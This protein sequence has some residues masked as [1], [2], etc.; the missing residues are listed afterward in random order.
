MTAWW[1]ELG[2]NARRL[3]HDQHLTPGALSPRSVWSH[4]HG[5]CNKKRRK[6]SFG[7]KHTF[8]THKKHARHS[9]EGYLYA[10]GAQKNIKSYIRNQPRLAKSY[11]KR[12]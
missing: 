5:G 10:Y 8:H 7:S 4:F 9:A 1:G 11:K 2:E 6:P 12:H 3:L